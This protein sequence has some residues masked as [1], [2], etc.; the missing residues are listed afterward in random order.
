M[1]CARDSHAASLRRSAREA[2]NRE[3]E[4]WS[5]VLEG[6][7]W[8]RSFE[9]E[10]AREHLERARLLLEQAPEWVCQLRSYAQLAHY[11]MG[12][13]PQAVALA[14]SGLAVLRQHHGPP[15]LVSSIDAVMSLAHV[16]LELWRAHPDDAS[17]RALARESLAYLARLALVFPVAR[18]Y[19]LLC[20]GRFH[21][22]LGRT[23]RA[24]LL[25]SLAERN[26][27]TFQLPYE[28]ALVAWHRAQL[29][30]AD[31]ELRAYWFERSRQLFAKLGSVVDA[32]M[33]A[34]G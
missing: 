26:A 2:G 10:R 12:R 15:V 6:S 21:A 14:D 4:I 5:E 33:L 17:K 29:S 1:R 28:R 20:A 30:A 24:R 11:N 9:Y 16:H 22:V 31:D 23:R 34:P 3:H 27:N 8:L 19:Y 32:A 18:A 25:L 13:T 7:C